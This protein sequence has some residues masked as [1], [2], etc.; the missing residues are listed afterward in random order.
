MTALSLFVWILA[1]LLLQVALALGLWV[2]RRG[3]ANKE[4]PLSSEEPSTSPGAWAGWRDFRVV[5][6]EFEDAARTQCSFHLSPV[7]GLPLEAFRP[8]QFLT[9][10]IPPAAG[11]DTIRGERSIARCYSLSDRPDPSSFR[12]T[13]KRQAAPAGRPDL[14]P[15]I[16]SSHFHDRVRE[17]D[18]LKVKA[19]AGRFVLEPDAAVPA[20]LIG[21]GCGITPLM[22]MLR[23]CAAEQPGRD[24]HLY[25]GVRNGGEQAFRSELQELSRSLRAFRLT[26]VYSRPGPQDEPGRDF[27]HEGHV[28][29]DLLRR[30]L[31]HG[32]HSFYLCGPV[33]MIA[34]LVKGLGRWG[35]PSNDIHFEAFTSASVRSVRELKEPF[36]GPAALFEVNFRRSGRTVP[37]DGREETLLEFAER[38]GVSI[39]SGCRAGSCGS[40]ETRLVAGT[41]SYA[42]PDHDL[43]PGHCLPCVSTPTSPLVLEA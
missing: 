3:S 17:G 21:G 43:K 27:Q 26:V 19:P 1:A 30:T 39:E 20:V 5:R 16:S 37:W 40:C 2:R 28:D 29:I 6:R 42:Y 9:F 25:Y 11:P 13:I 36:A 14:P 7:D 4:P 8:G 24:L 38:H 32:R 12:I 22:S 15:G 10:A 23:W 34:G 35:V 31:P 33:P 41:V 18:L